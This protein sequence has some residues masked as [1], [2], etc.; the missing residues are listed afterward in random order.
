MLQNSV[1]YS[2]PTADNRKLE[3]EQ[4][5]ETG[6][7]TSRS[8]PRIQTYCTRDQPDHIARLDNQCFASPGLSAL[9]GPASSPSP[10]T[11]SLGLSLDSRLTPTRTPPTLRRAR[12]YVEKKP[13]VVLLF[14]HPFNPRLL[15]GC[16]G[17][18]LHG[19]KAPSW[20]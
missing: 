16:Y 4:V 9:S 14:T 11:Q 13:P 5:P 2:P 12:T 10:R 15:Y 6:I 7:R 19:K 20:M 3:F 8:L 17:H 1:S 18:L